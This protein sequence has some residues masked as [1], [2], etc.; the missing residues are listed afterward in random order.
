MPL[1]VEERFNTEIRYGV[2]G[3]PMWS[4]DIVEVQS[5][6][7]SANI[8]WSSPLGRWQLSQDMYNK[9]ETDYLINFFNTRM[10]RA[11]GFRFK[12]WSDYKITLQ[13][14]SPSNTPNAGIATIISGTLLQLVRRYQSL[15]RYVDT[16]VLKPVAGTVTLYR[17][18]VPMAPGTFAVDTTTGLIQVQSGT[19]GAAWTWTG[20]FDKPVRFDTDKMDLLFA[21]YRESDGE[22]MF[23]VQNLNIKEIRLQLSTVFGQTAVPTPVIVASVPPPGPAPAPAPTPAPAPAPAPVPAPSPGTVQPF[24]MGVN[25]HTIL[26]G[27][28]VT[29]STD[30]TTVAGVLSARHLTT[31]RDIWWVHSTSTETAAVRDQIAKNN[32]IGSRTQLIIVPNT[33]DAWYS[34]TIRTDL[35]ALTNESYTEM[36]TA[37]NTMGDIVSDFEFGNELDLASTLTAQVPSGSAGSVAANYTGH[38]AAEAMAAILLGMH[39][40]LVAYRGQTGKNIRHIQGLVTRNWGW[41]QFLALRGITWDLTGYHIYPH[42]ADPAWATDTWFGTGGLFTQ[43]NQFGKP[44]TINE[45]NAGEIFDAGYL[46][47]DSDSHTQEGW[48]AV[49]S[50]MKQMLVETT[51]HIDSVLWYELVDEPSKAPPENM[52]GLMSDYSTPKTTLMLASAFSG[53]TLSSAETTK[54]TSTY[55]LLTTTEINSYKTPTSAPPP[56]PA[57]APAPGV[58]A[59]PFGSRLTGYASGVILPTDTTTNFDNFIKAQ[60]TYWKNNILKT[61][62]TGFGQVPAGGYYP[63]YSDPTFATVSEGIGYAMLLAVSMAGYDSNAQVIFDGL[64]KTVR[65]FPS[66]AA[67]QFF[68]DAYYAMSWRVGADGSDQGGGWPALDGDL[69]I[70]MALIMA[71]YQWG[72][73]GTSFNYSTEATRQINAIRWNFHSD[74]VIVNSKQGN[75]N[76]TSDYM[77]GHFRAFRRFTADTFWDSAVSAQKNLINYMQTNYSATAGLLPDWVQ[78]ADTVSPFPPPAGTWI[79]DSGGNL[80]EGEYWYNACRDPWRFAADYVHSG[81]A[82]MKTYIM[83]METFFRADSG[84]VPTNLVAGYN[85]DGSHLVPVNPGGYINPEFQCPILVGAM[86]D[87][88]MQ[89]WL[90]ANWQYTKSHPTTGYYS[91]EIQLLCAIIASG[92]W[93]TP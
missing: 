33:M 16:P 83:R 22:S 12:D 25:I 61:T 75:G 9:K 31:V 32:A 27:G 47:A 4:T 63:Q 43:L 55:P 28:S 14:S 64:L 5:G 41:L 50:F 87:G 20:E 62:S 79:G 18:G 17:N 85:L 71:N 23:E 13:P 39:N 30:R 73:G 60:Y 38:T 35:S 72:T 67:A 54:I 6:I 77:I 74:G 88:T 53:G 81:D 49:V 93:W 21:G 48:S 92:N 84:G 26:G 37:L 3:G 76:R 70:A 82:S 68:P 56:P 66:T 24:V 8:N 57:P 78:S 80:H 15:T 44:V 58:A 40:A 89:G 86:V 65:A 2:V 11:V 36:M 69:D 10:G 19:A 46:N 59:Y 29:S 90:D 34:G 52:F 45:F 91:T 1:F 42:L 51:V 7:E